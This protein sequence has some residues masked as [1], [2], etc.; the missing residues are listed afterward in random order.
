LIDR[1]L[2]T[3]NGSASF[4]QSCSARVDSDE[5]VG[6]LI[7]ATVL[8]LVLRLA[9]RVPDSQ[10]WYLIG[11]SS[12]ECRPSISM[13]ISPERYNSTKLWIVGGEHVIAARVFAFSS[14]NAEIGRSS[15]FRPAMYISSI[16]LYG[17]M[18]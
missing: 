10:S 12:G 8:S 17:T 1:L 14:G 16:V 11:C 13:P 6:E 9:T 2:I 18:P 3:N 5:A 7:T 4:W 15:T